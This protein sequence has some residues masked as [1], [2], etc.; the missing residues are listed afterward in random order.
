M[1][2]SVGMMVA[3]VVVKDVSSTAVLIMV[4][5]VVDGATVEGAMLVTGMDVK[6]SIEDSTDET[7][8]ISVDMTDVKTVVVE[9]EELEDKIIEDVAIV[10]NVVVIVSIGTTEDV[11][12]EVEVVTSVRGG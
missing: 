6:I 10:S 2:S 5:A 4:V 7:D 1:E 11:N 12:I 8:E 3:I 9:L